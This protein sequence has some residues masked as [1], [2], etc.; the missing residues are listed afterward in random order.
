MKT[1]LETRLEELKQEYEKGQQRL[2][3][4]DQER[5]NLNN[6]VLRISGAIHVLEELLK[7]QQN[8]N[9]IPKSKHTKHAETEKVK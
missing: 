7:E 4:L 2:M 5:N 9:S 3:N 1:E 8:E 6:I